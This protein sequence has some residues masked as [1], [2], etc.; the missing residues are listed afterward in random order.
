MAWLLIGVLLLA[1]GG[2]DE[3]IRL[4]NE[5]VELLKAKK[6]AEAVAVFERALKLS[7]DQSRIRGNL[8]SALMDDAVVALNASRPG[9]AEPRARRARELAPED[10]HV[11]HVLGT[12]LY[13]LEKR[14]EAEA[15]LK[16]AVKR[17]P[18]NGQ[19]QDLLGT[20]LYQKEDLAGAIAAWEEALKLSPKDE[21]LRER[22]DKAR[23]EREVEKDFIQSDT[24][25]FR[26]RFD[27]SAPR[28]P[29]VVQG[30]MDLLED[31]YNV[32][33][34]EFG[35][36]P[37]GPFTVILYNRSEF[38][39]VTGTHGWVGGLF[40]GK[41]RLPVGDGTAGK[42]D[43]RQTVLHEYTHALVHRL[44]PRC[45]AWL[46]EG[47]AQLLE[48]RSEAESLA[49]LR[50]AKPD[51]LTPVADLP[52]SFARVPGRDQVT[53]LYA[54]SHAFTAHLART[55]SRRTL[56]ETL[57]AMGKSADVAEAFRKAAGAD[58][59]DAEKNWKATL[60]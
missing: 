9:D 3:A 53:L 19:A 2:E 26:V 42:L 57:R 5:G 29:Q 7:P 20:L 22:L 52:S 55:W 48:G 54:Q 4:N 59:A 60:R 12:A 49:T 38:E 11:A 33:G 46:N 32:V 58:L 8:V 18:G 27:V 56:V 21:A 13:R 51:E 50:R 39:G 47:L 31:A 25:H 45:P 36:F 23:R 1:L 17:D 43:L 6:P 35:D 14:E 15:E 28:R 24:G 10:G 41:I 34:A 44:A 40:D 37:P 30:V 16:R